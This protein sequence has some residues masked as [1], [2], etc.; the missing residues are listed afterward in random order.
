MRLIPRRIGAVALPVVLVAA[1]AA[2][3]SSRTV[4]EVPLGI[5]LTALLGGGSSGGLLTLLITTVLNRRKVHADTAKADAEADLAGAAARKTNAE[6]IAELSALVR[7]LET[8][9]A[10][11][12]AQARAAKDRA[13]ALA[14]EV[15]EMRSEVARLTARTVGDADAT[16]PTVPMIPV[17]RIVDER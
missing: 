7:Q 3:A 1:V 9:L 17:K 12:R 5:V 10:V 6:T 8:E 13:D 14:A 2:Y 15:E 16:T 11:V 4:E